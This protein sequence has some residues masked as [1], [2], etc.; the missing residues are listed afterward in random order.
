[1]HSD[2]PRTSTTYAISPRHVLLVVALLAALVLQCITS[3]RMESAT[4]D[5]PNYIAG[6]V[7]FLTF[8]REAHR[9]FYLGEHHPPL[10][11]LCNAVPVMLMRGINYPPADDAWLRTGVW[12]FGR[13]FLF[14][15]NMPRSEEIV[16][17]C[18]LAPVF[19]SMMLGLLVFRL[20]RRF[21]GTYAGLFA[22]FL[23]C[24]SPIILGISRYAVLDVCATFFMVLSISAFYEFLMKMS[25]RNLA[26]SGAAFG[27]AQLGKY[28]ALLLIPCYLI[29]F[30]I[31]LRQT[32]TR[33]GVGGPVLKL[34]A[35]FLIGYAVVW[36]GY[37]FDTGSISDI[38]KIDPF[39]RECGGGWS[40]PDAARRS[41]GTFRDGGVPLTAYLRGLW[42]LSQHARVG[43]PAFLLGRVSTQG[44]WYYYL[45]AFLLKTPLPLLLLLVARL[46]VRHRPPMKVGLEGWVL[47]VP[48]A[49][50]FLVSTRSHQNIGIRHILLVYPLIHVCLGGLVA[51]LPGG[52][53]GGVFLRFAI[54]LASAW[55]VYGSLAVGPHYLAYFNELAGGPKNGY[56]YL[57]D[58]NLDWGQD[59]KGV[60][61]Y[62]AAHQIDHILFEQVGFSALARHY[63]ISY[64]RLS[65]RL[66][67]ARSPE[68]A[69]IKG[70]V[71]VSATARADLWDPERRLYNWISRHEPVD[72]IGYSILVYRF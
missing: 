27:L 8:G 6:G 66:S 5:E 28:S 70:V 48:V 7:T 72:S 64:E 21:Y 57:V 52:S 30:A 13:H 16:H 32:G 3:L 43:H 55:Y 59:L 11:Y 24:F 62:M 56:K 1:M 50:T 53:A 45:V 34:C 39:V 23:Y 37:G 14:D 31:R 51:L 49:L 38:R 63:G 60:K 2:M 35:V 4:L 20:A 42:N 22:L 10:G 40:F 26:F 68:E 65:D 9:A 12:N 47:L 36:A 18:R 61:G 58:S 46:C 33:G 69:H 29:L 15:L 25:V 44:W 41:M 17:R 54:A 19:L 67:R 71:M